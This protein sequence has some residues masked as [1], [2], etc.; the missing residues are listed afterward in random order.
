MKL[1]RDLDDKKLEAKKMEDRDGEDI[2]ANNR[3]LES[4][5]PNS[6]SWRGF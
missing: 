3:E 1:K 5:P 4:D 2:E 6:S